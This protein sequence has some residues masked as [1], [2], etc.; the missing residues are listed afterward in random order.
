M[1][2]AVICV[3]L[4]DILGQNK[5]ETDAIWK[6]SWRLLTQVLEQVT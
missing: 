2:F 1:H 6:S 5:L 3:Q 4:L